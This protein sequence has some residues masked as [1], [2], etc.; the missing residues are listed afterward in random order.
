MTPAA[1]GTYGVH[2]EKDNEGVEQCSLRGPAPETKAL[3]PAPFTPLGAEHQLYAN[4]SPEQQV[5]W[6][7][8]KSNK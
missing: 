6:L 4:V 5:R 2:A 7:T 8:L 1:R 3:Q